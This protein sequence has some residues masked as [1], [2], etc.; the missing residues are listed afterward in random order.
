MPGGSFHIPEFSVFL[1]ANHRD[2]SVSE[3][4]LMALK[5]DSL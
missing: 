2:A 4:V 1:V 3:K 5:G